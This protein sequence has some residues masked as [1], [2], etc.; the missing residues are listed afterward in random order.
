L[1]QEAT[2]AD[3][4]SVTVIGQALVAIHDWTFLLG[5]ALAERSKRQDDVFNALE[6]IRGRLPFRGARSGFR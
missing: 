5:P 2:G 6:F 4:A 1:R 3:A